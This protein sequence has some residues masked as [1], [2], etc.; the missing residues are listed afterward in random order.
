MEADFMDGFTVGWFAAW[1]L[2]LF[3]VIIGH[4]ISRER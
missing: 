1:G 4:V 2:V 3:A